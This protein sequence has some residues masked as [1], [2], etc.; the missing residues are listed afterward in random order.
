MR[1]WSARSGLE[2]ATGW[3]PSPTPG[4]PADFF[5]A[6]LVCM[7]PGTPPSNFPDFPQPEGERYEKVPFGCQPPYGLDYVEQDQFHPADHAQ[8]LEWAGLP[9][10]GEWRSW[11]AAATAR[12]AAAHGLPPEMVPIAECESRHRPWAVNRRNPRLVELRFRRR[13]SVGIWMGC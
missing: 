7:S 6:S 13:R 12:V 3:P 11:S 10:V 4:N 2:G 5:S 8:M 9:P 1:P